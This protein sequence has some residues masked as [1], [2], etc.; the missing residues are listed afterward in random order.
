MMSAA[1]PGT[2]SLGTTFFF[3]F[4]VNSA[5]PFFGGKQITVFGVK[6]STGTFEIRHSHIQSI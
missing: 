3:F 5:E 4:F 2:G 1:G 6:P